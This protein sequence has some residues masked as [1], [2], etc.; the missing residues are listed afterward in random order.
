MRPLFDEDV[1]FTMAG[2]GAFSVKDFLDAKKKDSIITNTFPKQQIPFLLHLR[3]RAQIYFGNVDL[4]GSKK[5]GYR[6]E[7]TTG[8]FECSHTPIWFPPGYKTSREIEE[9]KQYTVEISYNPRNK[10]T[11][12]L[13]VVKFGPG[14]EAG[15][16]GVIVNKIFE[17][18]HQQ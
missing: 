6:V 11:F 14:E 7:D 9:G 10:T 3:N 1:D 18:A 5:K 16:L 2:Y 13:N 15:D 12:L 17:L 8:D 4:Y